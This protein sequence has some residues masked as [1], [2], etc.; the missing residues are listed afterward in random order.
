MA[1]AS[2]SPTRPGPE[3]SNRNESRLGRCPASHPY[4]LSKLNCRTEGG[5]HLDNLGKEEAFNHLLGVSQGSTRSYGQLFFIFKI[6]D[7]I[8]D[9]MLADPEN[10]ASHIRTSI[11][12]RLQSGCL[13]DAFRDDISGR[14][15]GFIW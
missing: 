11:Y 15:L 12:I 2:A 7:E 9:V 10:E 8:E 13:G 5:R 4:L 14:V 3:G 6:S 1:R